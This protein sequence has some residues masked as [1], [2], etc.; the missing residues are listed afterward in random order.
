MATQRFF[1]AAVTF[2]Y[3]SFMKTYILLL[4]LV[5]C[6]SVPQQKTWQ[7]RSNELATEFALGNAER[8]P[9]SASSAGY[10]Q[11]DS[12]TIQMEVG[13][14]DQDRLYWKSWRER[15]EKLAKEETHVELRT[16]YEVLL[17]KLVEWE[18]SLELEK[19]YSNVH[20]CFPAKTVF[21]SL[22]GLINHQTD[23]SRKKAAI[24]RFKAYV[25][26]HGRFKP[27]LLACEERTNASLA[28]AGP[29]TLFPLKKEVAQ[30]LE[31]AASFLSGTEKLLKESG[32]TDWEQE[33]TAYKRQLKQHDQFLKEKLLPRARIDN[34]LPR[35]IYAFTLQTYGINAT[36]EQLIQ[37][38]KKDYEITY[39]E[40]RALA[41][42]LAKKHGLRNKSP[43]SVIRFLKRKQLTK[44][45]DVE[46]AYRTADQLLTRLIEEHSLVSL[47]K[48]PLVI[49]VAG[50]AESK[51]S[52][53]PHLTMPPFINN[54]GERPEF[55]VPSSAAGTLGFDDFSYEASAPVLTAHEGRPGHDLQFSSMLDNGVS[56]IRARYAMNSVNAE[57]WGLYAEFLMAPYLS[58]E[59]Q[60]VALQTR[61]WRM[62]RAFLD[63]QIQLG[64]DRKS[65]V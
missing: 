39:R 31:D 25:N 54:R 46:L 34:R 58:Q 16:D 29:R 56:I 62:A 15:L 13:M 11:F 33:L 9:E 41:A 44:A 14:E 22:R 53:V 2:M 42:T 6:S 60:L 1:A 55:V 17:N 27:L 57:G 30:Y 61:L 51:A 8:Y 37:M 10:R 35:E 52:P 43:A 64:Q 40:F 4:S 59:S 32:R 38:A 50:E 65:V 24:D 23:T 19:K 49:R 47:P 36:P 26:G 45:S 63:P 28:E 5:A 21:L 48:K 3:S 12:K 20:Y 18:K 7:E